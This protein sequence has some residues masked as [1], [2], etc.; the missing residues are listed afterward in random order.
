[1]LGLGRLLLGLLDGFLDGGWV[2][3]DDERLLGISFVR[4][5]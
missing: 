5:G 1:M 4:D 2:A 3:W